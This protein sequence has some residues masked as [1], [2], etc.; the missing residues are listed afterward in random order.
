M[1]FQYDLVGDHYL[2]YLLSQVESDEEPVASYTIL[3]DHLFTTPFEYR[4]PMD[5][6][7]H[8]DGLE[9]RYKYE[10]DTGLKVTPP[11]NLVD[12]PSVLEVMVALAERIDLIASVDHEP[13]NP[14]WFWSMLGNAGYLVYTDAVLTTELVG[15]ENIEAITA[16]IL[17]RE[18][19]SD[20][21][22]SWFP[23]DNPHVDQ[24]GIQ[25]WEQALG[26]LREYYGM[27]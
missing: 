17:Y 27:E 21:Y 15:L 18:F 4:I 7:R 23:L 12:K 14:Y 2:R 22:G 25:I 19:L 13:T 20:G 6:N 3:L 16:R 8:E 1:M 24:R 10:I 26:Y 11:E 5:V 9:T